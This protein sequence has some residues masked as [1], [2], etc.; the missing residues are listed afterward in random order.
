MKDDR[1]NGDDFFDRWGPDGDFAFDILVGEC[2]VPPSREVFE[3][4]LEE[5]RRGISVPVS[6]QWY[7][8]L[9]ADTYQRSTP[10]IL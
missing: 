6:A 5:K 9:L 3:C 1:V 4:G 7:A 8:R 2:E 10:P